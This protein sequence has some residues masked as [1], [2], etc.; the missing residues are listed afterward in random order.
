MVAFIVAL[1]QT[2]VLYPVVSD[3]IALTTRRVLPYWLFTRVAHSPV[4][5]ITL[6]SFHPNGRVHAYDVPTPVIVP[7]YYHVLVVRPF[8]NTEYSVLL[9]PFKLP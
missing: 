9:F 8:H 1:S 2:N 4:V 5:D 7:A 3:L 6:H